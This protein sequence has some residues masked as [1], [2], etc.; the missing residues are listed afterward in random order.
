MNISTLAHIFWRNIQY[1]IKIIFG[2]KFVYFLVAAVAFYLV[3]V[4]IMLFSDWMPAENDIYGILVFPGLLIMFYPVVYNIQSDKDSRM[5]EIIF[6]VPNYRYKVYLLRFGI[7]ILILMIIIAAM[8]GFASFAIL[9]INV[10]DMVYKLSYTLLF[11]SSLA[12]LLSTLTKNGNGTAV[13]LVVIGLV[14]FFLKDPLEHN[15]WYIF[16][17]PYDMPGDLSP[18]IWQSVIRQ[19][20]IILGIG[21][22]VSVLWGLINL[23]GREKFV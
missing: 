15:K 12:F 20:R 18:T 16:L 5:L 13:A 10:L 4:G 17:N 2:N 3:L 11:M 21:I 23:Q 9:K 22:I 1:N 7:S 19:N 8:S 6:G 14:F